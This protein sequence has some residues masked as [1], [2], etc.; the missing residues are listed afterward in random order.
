MVNSELQEYLRE[1]KTAKQELNRVSSLVQESIDEIR[2]IASALHPHHLDGLGLRAALETIVDRV[3]HSSKVIFHFTTDEIDN[4][5]TKDVRI[6]I[7]RIVQEAVSNIARHS[8][9]TKATIGIRRSTGEVRITVLDDGKGFDAQQYQLIGATGR[10]GE[11]SGRG[12]GLSSMTE[13]ARL[14]GGSLIIESGPG[15]G[16]RVAVIIP[17]AHHDSRKS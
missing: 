14:I 17:I 3:S 6:N 10:D 16:T 11:H 4:L 7:F 2:E 5:F 1:N 15:E 12:F 13:R 9:A 8:G